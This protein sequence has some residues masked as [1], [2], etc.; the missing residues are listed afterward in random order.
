MRWGSIGNIACA[1]S[2][3]K[4]PEFADRRARTT[5]ESDAKPTAPSRRAQHRPA[6]ALRSTRTPPMTAAPP[7]PARRP[8]GPSS[9]PAPARPPTPPRPAPCSPLWAA[10]SRSRGAA[11]A[12][13]ARLRQ[14]SCPTAQR[15]AERLAASAVAALRARGAR[16]PAPVSLLHAFARRRSSS[17]PPAFQRWF[18]SFEIGRRRCCNAR[19]DDV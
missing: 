1:S 13:A 4:E 12:A 2:R 17:E 8:R 3:S 9:P 5:A 18:A 15:R 19:T 10:A 16:P 14:R 11:T 7:V 6:P